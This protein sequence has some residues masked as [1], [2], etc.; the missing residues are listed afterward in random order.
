MIR[1]SFR[2]GLV[3]LL[4]ALPSLRLA[5]H[6]RLKYPNSRTELRMPSALL[7]LLKKKESSPAVAP[8]S[9]LLL[10]Y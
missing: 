5:A 2:K 6:P 9:F 1:R 10:K 7:E 3:D 8:P 4:E